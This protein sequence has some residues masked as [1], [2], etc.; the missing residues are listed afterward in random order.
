MFRYVLTMQLKISFICP[1]LLLL[2]PSLYCITSYS[3]LHC[4]LRIRYWGQLV[5]TQKIMVISYC[6]WPGLGR[7]HL[8]NSKGE[9]KYETC[10]L[11]NILPGEQLGETLGGFLWPFVSIALMFLALNVQRQ[12]VQEKDFFCA[13][14]EVCM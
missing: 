5:S 12:T 6:R 3:L 9:K 11:M 7:L 2:S 1:L 8:G 13:C 4:K 14:Q 10:F